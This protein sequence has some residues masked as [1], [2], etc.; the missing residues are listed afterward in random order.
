MTDFIA[1]VTAL[2]RELEAAFARAHNAEAAFAT[3]ATEHVTRA[4]LHEC[5]D[6]NELARW[7]LSAAEL[8][9]Q[10]DLRAEFGDPPITL[11]NNGRFFI[12]ALIWRSSSTVV[13]QHAFTG[14]FQVLQGSSMHARYDYEPSRVFGDDLSIGTLRCSSIER[15][16]RGTVRTIPASTEGIHSLFHLE[17]PSVSLVVRTHTDTR[18]PIQYT[19]HPPGLA[20]WDLKREPR[21]VRALQTTRMLLAVDAEQ[22][23]RMLSEVL[24]DMPPH[25][26]FALLDEARDAEDLGLALR[27]LG[28]VRARLDPKLASTFELAL[29][30]RDRQS[31]IKR[32]REA[33][34]DATLRYFLA[35]LQN[36]PSRA[37]AFTLAEAHDPQ[38]PAIDTL[39]DW[40]VAL[41]RVTIQVQVAGK[42][43]EPNVFGLPPADEASLN[44]LRAALSD[45]PVSSTERLLLYEAV[46]RSSTFGPLFKH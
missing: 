16:T 31:Y 22:A 38:R 17:H 26:V 39:L 27:V 10:H 32:R 19:Y 28:A 13:H 7:A 41:T 5:F 45:R 15:L 20:I 42:A 40:L 43:W 14:A 37:H 23:E 29:I 18:F 12:S 34:P 36:A 1:R 4:A 21:Q 8:P 6:L 30:E 35:I 24:V 3:L 44:A 46:T 11:W 9:V 2:G 33:V 25:D